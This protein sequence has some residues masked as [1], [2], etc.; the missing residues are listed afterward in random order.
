MASDGKS[1]ITVVVVVS[2]ED[3]EVTVQTHQDVSK[4]VREALRESGNAGQPPE[5]WVLK[6][7]AGEI[8]QDQTITAAGIVDGMKLRL[9]PE[10]GE[11]GHQ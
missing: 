2:G 1:K 5:D 4:L 7:D 10:A 3:V 9:T 11:G 6:G 8:A